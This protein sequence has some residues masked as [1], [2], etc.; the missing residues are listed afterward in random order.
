MTRFRIFLLA[1]T[2]TVL[3]GCAT[4]AQRLPEPLRAP[5]AVAD[6][7]EP[8]ADPER[9]GARVEPGPR[10]E[11]APRRIFD[12][13][14]TPVKPGGSPVSLALDGVNLTAFIDEVFGNQLGFSLEIDQAVRAKNDL[15]SLRLVQPEPPHRVYVIAEEAAK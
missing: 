12:A 10:T 11:V 5:I 8:E 6:A 4:P 15:V 9:R 2:L 3:A 1:V 7:G 13:A 14:R